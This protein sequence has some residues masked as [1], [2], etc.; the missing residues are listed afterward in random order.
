MQ[1]ERKSFVFVAKSA[2]AGLFAFVF[3]ISATIAVSPAHR[4]SHSSDRN[5]SGHQCVYCLFAHGQIAAADVR[6]PAAPRIDVCSILDCSPVPAQVSAADFCLSPS[7]APP[8]SFSVI[9]VG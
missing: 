6:S 2:L 9:A 8:A 7:R 1:L 4:Q 3:L 5:A